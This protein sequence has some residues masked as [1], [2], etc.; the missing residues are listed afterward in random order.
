MAETFELRYTLTNLGWSCKDCGALVVMCA[1]HDRWH[2]WL[3]DQ[4]HR[5]G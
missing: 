2:N 1:A 5:I 3:A 4:L